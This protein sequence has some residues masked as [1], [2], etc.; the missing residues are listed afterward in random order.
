MIRLLFK[1]L[2]Y[3]VIPLILLVLSTIV[4]FFIF[5]LYNIPAETVLYASALCILVYLPFFVT[6]Y[7]KF[8]NKH[9]ALCG[10]LNQKTTDISG[11][12]LS[13]NLIENDYQEILK[14]LTGDISSLES[15]YIQ[16]YS[17]MENYY[18]MWVHQIKTPIAAAKLLIQANETPINAELNEQLFKIECYADMVLEYFRSDSMSSDLVIKEYSLDSIVKKAVKKYADIFIRK[19]IRLSY[20]E[21]NKTVLT[22]EKW[23][24]FVIEQLL[25]NALKYTKSGEIS[26][27]MESSDSDILVISDTGIGISP[28]DIPLIFERGYT[29]YNG[30]L[31]KKSTGIGL[32]LCKKI[33]TVL[34]HKIE[35]SSEVSKGTS[36]RLY[37]DRKSIMDE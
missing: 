34:S 35:I 36:V 37:F 27:K 5:I 15:E 6:G 26:I 21:L 4:F 7:V 10:I 31:N 22:D 32:F 13:D 30:R 33:L 20:T 14:K 3:N 8:K 1:Y 24:G 9:I 16:K 2:K 18:T 29:G 12:L 25:S 23:L 19:N 11:I 28:E 17:D